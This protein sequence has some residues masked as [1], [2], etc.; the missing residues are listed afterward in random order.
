MSAVKKLLGASLV[1]VVGY[2]ATSLVVGSVIM[3]SQVDNDKQWFFY[4]VYYGLQGELLR[5]LLHF[6]RPSL[7]PLIV[8]LFGGVLAVFLFRRLGR[9]KNQ[10]HV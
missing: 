3:R 2:I 9:A 8:E 7:V 1:F 5:P 4:T 6:E 10:T